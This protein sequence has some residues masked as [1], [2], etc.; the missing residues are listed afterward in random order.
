MKQ[1]DLDFLTRLTDQPAL[2]SGEEIQILIANVLN[3]LRGNRGVF[4]LSER[5][6]YIGNRFILSMHFILR[7]TF[8]IETGIMED[9]LEY[10]RE[11]MNYL[12]MGNCRN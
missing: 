1:L 10:I 12:L 6:V 5:E 9:D 11:E 4:N 8:D 2:V 3:T 7:L